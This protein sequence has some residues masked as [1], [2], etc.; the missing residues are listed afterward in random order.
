MPQSRSND[1]AC[2]LV[3]RFMFHWNELEGEM[4]RCLRR[5]YDV[6][7]IRGTIITRNMHTREKANA[8]RTCFDFSYRKRRKRV[9]LPNDWNIKASKQ[10]SEINRLIFIRNDFVHTPFEGTSKGEVKFRVVK[11]TKVFQEAE[12]IWTENDIK[13]LCDELDTIV[14][15]IRRLFKEL[16]PG[17]RY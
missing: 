2:Q 1:R 6:G 12:A 16:F 5:L 7:F 15:E 17:E 13:T 4:D 9:P 11:A 14:L 3:G 8:L 10:L